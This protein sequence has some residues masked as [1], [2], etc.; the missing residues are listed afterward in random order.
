[1]LSDVL[2]RFRGLVGQ[3]VTAVRPN[4]PV[5]DLTVVFSGGFA[6]STF[7][8]SVDGGSWTLRCIDGQRLAMTALTDYESATSE[9][10]DG[11]A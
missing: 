4:A 10:P 3:T 7:S 8:H 2:A 11:Q 1:M 6:L 9:D 5:I